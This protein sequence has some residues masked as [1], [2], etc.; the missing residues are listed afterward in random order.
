MARSS[1]TA[2]EQAQYEKAAE[3]DPTGVLA[4]GEERARAATAAAVAEEAAAEAE[5][6]VVVREALGTAAMETE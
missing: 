6:A 1:R 3:E 4:E 5:R 2:Q